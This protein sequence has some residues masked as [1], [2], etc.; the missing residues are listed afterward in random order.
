MNTSPLARGRLGSIG[1]AA[2][3]SNL[4]LWRVELRRG[5]ARWLG[6]LEYTDAASLHQLLSAVVA[7]VIAILGHG[8]VVTRFILDSPLSGFE[9]MLAQAPGMDRLIYAGMGVALLT[10]MR[11]RAGLP[12]NLTVSD[13]LDECVHSLYAP[14][15]RSVALLGTLREVIV[16]SLFSWLPFFG[17]VSFAGQ[18][19][20]LHILA[21]G[22]WAVF[23]GLLGSALTAIARG[24]DRYGLLA[25]KVTSL[26]LGVYLFGG[27]AASFYLPEAPWTDTIISLSTWPWTLALSGGA[28]LAFPILLVGIALNVAARTW[29]LQRKRFG[30]EANIGHSATGA[31]SLTATRPTDYD[32]THTKPEAI[33]IRREMARLSFALRRSPV[34]IA[35]VLALPFMYGI[36]AVSM[37]ELREF[38]G[39]PDQFA[40][41]LTLALPVVALEWPRLIW[42]GDSRPLWGVVRSSLEE[43]M[44][45][46]WF[47]TA[48]LCVAP[49]VAYL[50]M[51]VPFAWV[52]GDPRVTVSLL[53]VA[54][55]FVMIQGGI[56]AAIGFITLRL[57]TPMGLLAA[58]LNM[59]CAIF[60]GL[61]LSAGL[62]RLSVL[63]LLVLSALAG[64]AGLMIAQA[65]LRRTEFLHEA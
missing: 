49:L 53:G 29:F 19:S 17:L 51:V 50:A 8:W 61:L 5:R 48:S 24:W 13:R 10:A 56:S 15:V 1:S 65:Q 40:V 63:E 37:P 7:V 12:P 47:R 21:V 3:R 62:G 42:D 57:H 43:P 22:S 52:A 26:L 36:L 11:Y 32:A 27:M 46:L 44:L 58:V 55:A 30:R 38:F 14:T 64:A 41:L 45:A 20:L 60:G 6:A 35:L 23:F 2:L 33:L 54:L 28:F 9:E 4:R 25:T 16:L 31:R 39:V 18:L 59:L 34:R